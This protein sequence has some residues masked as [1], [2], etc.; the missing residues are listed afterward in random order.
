VQYRDGDGS[1]IVERMKMPLSLSVA[2]PSARKHAPAL[3]VAAVLVAL[4]VGVSLLAPWP[5]A[6]AIDYALGGKTPTGHLAFLSGIDPTKLLILAAAAAVVLTIASGLLEMA[7]MRVAEGASERIGTELRTR[8]FERAMTRS[9]RWHDRMRSGELVSRLTTDVG[10]VQDGVVA[11]ATS[12]LPDAIMLFAV[13]VLLFVFDPT[14]LLIG[15]TVVPVLAALAVR[16]RNRIRA[17]QMDARMESGRLSGATTDLLRNVR[18]VQAFGRA[19]RANQEFDKTNQA[20]LN[21]ELRAI[22]VE[23]RWT[24][25]AD[26]LL[27]IGSALVLLVGGLRV[28][29]G[30][31]SIGV[32]LV[33]TTYLRSL[34]APVNGLTKLS[35]TLA[36]AGASATRLREVLDCE[37]A[38]VDPPNASTAPALTRYVEFNQVGFSYEQEHPVLDNFDLRITAGETVCLI[39]PSGIG[40]STALHLLLRL[41]DADAGRILIDGVD[42][43]SCDQHS[44][45]NRF[46]YVPQDPW[47]LDATVAE[48][49]AFGNPKATHDDVLEAGRAALVDEF[50]GRL[51]HGYDTP[52]GESG[53]RLSGGQRRRVAI[54]RAAISN[55]PMVLLDEPTASLDPRSAKAVIN[56]IRT[57]TTNRTV[58]VVTH[59]RD[60]AAIA[61]RV[62]TLARSPIQGRARGP[63]INAHLQQHGRR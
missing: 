16:Q 14:L 35:A 46:A 8:M 19:D 62:V 45:R 7:S 1:T 40:K 60:L 5:L 6:L 41:Y 59:D 11:L 4:Q 61:D 9:L 17:V 49:I 50:I 25:V 51:P 37:E 63:Q 13:L 47:L 3:G 34:Y 57:A 27:S 29:H 44:V 54:A 26:I 20:V 32:L 28:L 10:R 31:M 53:I 43:R 56:A 2:G 24:P 36:K 12:F 30:S 22:G 39:G 18:A 38:V 21:V 33:V 58:L 15:L 55:A 23:A 52:L 42:V 48:N